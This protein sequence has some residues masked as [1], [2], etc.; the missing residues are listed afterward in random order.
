MKV[1]ELR[2]SPRFLTYYNR[3][4][5]SLETWISL[6]YALFQ[7]GQKWRWGEDENRVFSEANTALS[8]YK[9]SPIT[10]RGS[11]WFWSATLRPIKLALFCLILVMGVCSLL[12][13]DRGL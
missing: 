6:L 11:G 4:V 9:F 7:K 10:I 1:S 13:S 3:F 5:P 2:S 12:H 8:E